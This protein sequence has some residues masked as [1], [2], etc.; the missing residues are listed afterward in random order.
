MPHQLRRII[1]INIRNPSD[2]NPSGRISELDPRG[3]V[4]AVGDNGVGKTT[5]LRLIPL[6]YGATPSQV[7][8]G[9]GKA[10]MIRHTLPDPSSAVAYEYERE[11]DSHLRTV[12]MYAKDGEDIPDFR[13]VSA[14]FDETF[15]Y[16]ENNTFVTRS[17]FA[18]RLHARNINVSPVLQLNE[19]RSVILNE[20]M[21]SKNAKQMMLLARDHSL[22]PRPL[23]NLNQIAAAMA[24]EKI[25]FRDLQNIVLERVAEDQATESKR[26]NV[27]ELKQ[28]REDVTTW[29]D[30]RTH[31]ADILKR[32]PDADRMK[33]RIGRIKGVHMELCSLHV[34]VKAALAQ[35]ATDHERL[36]SE[37]KAQ[38]EA[39]DQ[40]LG[41][42][43]NEITEAEQ[44]KTEAHG[45]WQRLNEAF[46]AVNSRQNH[47]DRIDA[48]TLEANESRE[49]ALRQQA[50]DK[51]KEHERLTSASGSLQTEYE[52]RCL[53]IEQSAQ[54]QQNEIAERKATAQSA[55]VKKRLA[56]GEAKDADLQALEEPPRLA[57]IAKERTRL[58][59]REGEINQ[60]I[61]N[62]AATDETLAAQEEAEAILEQRRKDFDAARET[63]LARD[64]DEAQARGELEAAVKAVEGLEASQKALLD[65][66]DALTAQVTPEPGS[67]LAFIRASD[68]PVWPH[69]SKLIAEAVIH[70][71]DLSPV[72][73]DIPAAQRGEE[74]AVVLGNATVST[75][76]LPLPEWFSM[77]SVRHQLET[78][79]GQLANINASVDRAADHAETARLKLKQAGTDHDKAKAHFGLAKSAFDAAVTDKRRLD[80]LVKTERSAAETKARKDL[81]GLRT[82]L[83]V[84]DNEERAIREGVKNKREA[85][86][87]GYKRKAEVLEAESNS[88]I[89]K[90]DAESQGVEAT[91]QTNLTNARQD[92][93][94]KLAG[95]GLDTVR[96]NAVEEEL[97]G[98]RDQLD[99]IANNRHEVVAWKKFCKDELPHFE[100]TRRKVGELHTAYLKASQNLGSL[101]TRRNDLTKE[102]KEV[103]DALDGRISTAANDAQR[104]QEL[105]DQKLKDFLDFVPSSAYIGRSML[106]LDQEV[107]RKLRTLVDEAAV[108]RN[109]VLSL[110][111]EFEKKEGGP[112]DWLKLKR[113]ELP[114]R[115]TRLE[116]EYLWLE[117][118]Q[119]CDWFERTECG[120]YIE[121]LTHQMNGF[122]ENASVFVSR[123]DTFDR[124]VATFNT[125]LGRALSTAEHFERFKNLSVR[126]TS[127]VGQQA[128]LS[129]LRK[130]RDKSPTISLTGRAYSRV[131]ME[132]P[133]DEDTALV[134][135]YKEILRSDGGVQVDLNE[136]VRLEFSLYENGKRSVISN[137]EEFR[138]VSSNGNSA[139]IT[140][141]FLMGFVQMIRGSSPVRLVWVTDELGRFDA[142]NVGAFLKTLALNNI[143]V[144]SASPSVDPALARHFPRLSLFE[145][146]GA[147]F[148]NETHEL[149][150]E[151][152]LA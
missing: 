106:E 51:E 142:K 11:S 99:A 49:A 39:F 129:V 7:L 125:E 66:I 150:A 85:I 14:G 80:S 27:R 118:E 134:R 121:Q 95:M 102:A 90:L 62:P 54:R 65:H 128:F 146:T 33:E 64:K 124:L 112:N 137:E 101:E 86:N 144:I 58:A 79:K 13:I 60:Q 109:E 78:A 3:G 117:A 113:K 29:L 92:Y 47:F 12:V 96:I 20:R 98:L 38:A 16:D 19:Y 132:L 56:L 26:Q 141:M 8:K 75:Q 87:A 138:A 2:S 43:G 110:R 42:L 59:T 131:G 114:D 63:A 119:L 55:G 23:R 105:R 40:A 36:S 111:N 35:A 93:E 104:L 127:S 37:R 71:T 148:T 100:T 89:N 30:S 24:N 76:E 68:D 22:G 126:V 57:E 9:S 34:A 31:M 107:T 115:Q 61:K 94:R 103:L 1:A 84:L 46:L 130:M 81:D 152:E 88:E 4:L 73:L 145:N 91:L 82:T 136:Q 97:K 77:D 17:E 147:I 69:A 5:F 52:R 151:H 74:G 70:R 108:L 48:K 133:S 21:S 15:F 32:K 53:E 83:N 120:S 116:H 45:D 18:Q 123:L 28:R 135:E 139:L 67:L 72:M 6:F 44:K 149:E 41:A 143:D 140:A 25:S 10:S 50:R 122:F